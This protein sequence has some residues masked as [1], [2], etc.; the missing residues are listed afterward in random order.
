LGREL[1]FGVRVGERYSQYWRVGTDATRPD[2]YLASQRTGSFIQVSVHDPRYGMH[3]KVTLPTGVIRNTFPHPTP[4]VPGVT[5]LAELRVPLGAVTH[6]TPPAKAVR[7]VGPVEDTDV[8]TAFEV[9]AEEPGAA[10]REAEWNRGT[11]LVGRADRADGGTIAV[12]V[13]PMRGEGG[14][15]AMSAPT[16]GEKERIREVAAQGKLRALVHGLNPDGSLW[17]LELRGELAA[18]EGAATGDG[19]PPPPAE[20]R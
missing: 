3:V 14:N 18:P 7:W 15:L 9:L 1:R 8:W 13:W 11:L 6:D 20:R 5:R 12:A 19:T 4:L 16:P 17:F 2:V 10:A